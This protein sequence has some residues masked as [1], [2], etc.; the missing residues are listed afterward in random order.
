VTLGLHSVG[1]AG[2]DASLK[3][4][5]RSSGAEAPQAPTLNPR[6][7]E[8]IRCNGVVC[9]SVCRSWTDVE[10]FG[11]PGGRGV[12]TK[13]AGPHGPAVFGDRCLHED[14]AI[15]FARLVH[16]TLASSAANCS[17]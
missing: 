3:D 13:T 14:P 11:G 9:R 6:L 1:T 7:P 8:P 15:R 16:A 12:S 10:G 17:I 2:F 4:F 5:L